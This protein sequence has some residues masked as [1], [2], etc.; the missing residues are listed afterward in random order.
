MSG[1]Q[2]PVKLPPIQDVKVRNTA[3]DESIPITT[4]I[5]NQD[6][7]DQLSETINLLTSLQTTLTATNTLLSQ[8]IGKLGA[9]LPTALTGSNQLRVS[10]LLGL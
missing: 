3:F 8:V 9:G 1:F 5:T 4:A 2:I 10:T 6:I 7:F